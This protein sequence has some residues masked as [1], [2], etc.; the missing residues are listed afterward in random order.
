MAIKGHS[1]RAF[2][3]NV[4][5]LSGRNNRPMAN[6]HQLVVLNVRQARVNRRV[7]PRL[8]SPSKHLHKACVNGQRQRTH[9]KK[10]LLP[11]ESAQQPRPVKLRVGH[12]LLVWLL[13]DKLLP[14]HANL[15]R[16]GEL[17]PC[18]RMGQHRTY[19]LSNRYE[20]WPLHSRHS[21]QCLWSQ[22]RSQLS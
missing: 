21:F 10:V 18:G 12:Q 3:Q 1:A 15:A 5:R 9:R 13:L 2:R 11:N 20:D 17:R 4:R 22:A 16:L 7:S 6:Q 14:V 8:D 19:R